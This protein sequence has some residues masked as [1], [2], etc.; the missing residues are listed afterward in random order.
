MTRK[1]GSAQTRATFFR[2]FHAV[3][4]LPAFLLRKLPNSSH[5]LT[6]PTERISKCAEAFIGK[7]I[8]GYSYESTFPNS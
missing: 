8:D 2:H 3:P 6:I 4:S 7:F 1:I 5:Q